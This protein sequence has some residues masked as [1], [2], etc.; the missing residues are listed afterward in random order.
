MSNIRL[1]DGSFIDTEALDD[2]VDGLMP[3]EP[4]DVRDDIRYKPQPKQEKL[5]EAAGLLAYYKGEGPAVEPIAP[6]IG[7]GGAARGGKSYGMLGMAAVAAYAFPGVQ[8]VYYRRTYSEIEGAGSVMQNAYEVFWGVAEKRDNGRQWYFP[9]TGALFQFLHCENENDVYKYQSKSFDI[10]FIDEAT[11]FTWE[12]VDYILTRNSRSG[13]SEI[14]KPF[15]VFCSNPGNIGHS[16]Y[17]QLFDLER[18]A[19]KIRRGHYD[20]P[21]HVL[22]PNEK[23]SDVFFI[24]AFLEDNKIQTERDPDYEK[25]LMERNPDTAQALRWG[26]WDVFTGQMFGAF[27]EDRHVIEPFEIP[28]LWPKWRAIDWGNDKPFCCLWFTTNMDNG[29]LYVYRELYQ[30]NLTDK[31][32]AETIVLYTPPD[33]FI[34]FTWAD[35]SMWKSQNKDGMFYTT[36]DEYRKY[37]VP[38]TK[39]NNDRLGGIRKVHGVLAP[40]MDGKPGVQIF[41][42]CTN[43][44]RTLPKLSKN[45]SM[46]EDVAGGQEDH[47]FDTLKYGLTNVGILTASQSR[48]P[49]SNPWL[50]QKGI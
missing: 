30:A 21:R 34:S 48:K 10:I 2:F 47:A 28:R 38:L 6:I 50:E 8:M 44:I 26:L 5:L 36:A 49:Q 19:E 41:K 17:M 29:R 16:W 39:A 14:I 40:M 3:P 43:L 4:G 33:E 25:K 27:S 37:G 24:P 13:K 1:I 15:A 12:M 42:N 18:M 46:T 45:P 7:Y 32:Q 11:H 9:K 23:Y 22:T 31:L 20:E 35:P